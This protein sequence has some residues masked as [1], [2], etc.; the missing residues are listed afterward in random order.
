MVELCGE[1]KAYSSKWLKNRLKARYKE[2]VYFAELN[3]KPNVV[4]F[5]NI[6]DYL[7][8]DKWYNSRKES[9]EDEAER[10]VLTAAKI[11]R[12]NIRSKTYQIENYPEEE[13]ISNVEKGMEWLPKYLCIFLQAIIKTPTKVVSIGQAI[14]HI[15]RPR[16]CL[17]PVPFGL[18]VQVNHVFGSK[19]LISQLSRLG[20]SVGPEEVTRYKQSVVENEKLTDVLNDNFPGA[21]TQ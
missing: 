18:A 3:G 16:S 5:R 9:M 1:E 8:S 6:A 21:F 19:W 4:C 17:A 11:I 20:F 10:I 7:L 2:R 13:E 14:V 15:T 12:D